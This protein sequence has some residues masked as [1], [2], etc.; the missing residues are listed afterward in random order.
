MANAILRSAT[1]PMTCSALKTRIV[2]RLLLLPRFPQTHALSGDWYNHALYGSVFLLGFLIA[3]ADRV[4]F[5][6]SRF[7]WPALLTAAV[8]FASGLVLRQIYGSGQPL[9]LALKLYAG[10][11][12]GCYQWFCIVAVLGFAR[13]WLNRD[14]AARRYLTD[15]VFPYYIVH[16]T[17]I[18]LIAHHIRGLGLSAFVE[19]GIVIGDTVASYAATYE[20][21]VRRLRP[22]FG[23]RLGGGGRTSPGSVVFRPLRA[24]I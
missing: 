10:V 20:G 5:A 17:A 12:Y 9:P 13:L 2:Y 18:I 23:L 16:Q 1:M 4:W 19:A 6:I 24:E 8:M 15:V 22:L 7:R 21:R 3:R 11:A 14:N